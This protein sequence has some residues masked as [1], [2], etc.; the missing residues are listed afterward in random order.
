MKQNRL[1]DAFEH[2]NDEYINSSAEAL[3]GKRMYVFHFS[4]KQFKLVC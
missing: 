1:F 3:S 2:I 4:K